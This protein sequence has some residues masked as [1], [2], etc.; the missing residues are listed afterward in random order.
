MKY[1]Y[2]NTTRATLGLV[3]IMI[4]TAGHSTAQSAEIMG[5]LQLGNAYNNRLITNA[6]VTLYEATEAAPIER[7]SALTDDA[8]QFLIESDVDATESI[9][10]VT[11]DLRP[12][13]RFVTVLGPELPAETTINELTTVAASYS[14]AQFYRTG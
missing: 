9:F 3:L 11:A 8:G 14:M 4:V 7:G 1:F 5:T 12:R 10:F 6:Q 13:V 2:R